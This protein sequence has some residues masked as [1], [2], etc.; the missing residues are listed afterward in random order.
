MVIGVN[1]LQ[2]HRAPTAID[3]GLRDSLHGKVYF[4]KHYSKVNDI[5]IIAYYKTFS[6]SRQVFG[7]AL[8]I[9]M[10]KNI[11]QNV[12]IKIEN[13]AIADNLLLRVPIIAAGVYYDKVQY[14][15][16]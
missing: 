15:L 1:L 10:C 11:K 9:E 2:K 5:T 3:S 7:G 16:D 13:D 12:I 8:T 14:R 6:L 4:W